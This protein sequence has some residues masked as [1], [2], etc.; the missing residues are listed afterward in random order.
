MAFPQGS[1]YGGTQIYIKGSGF[2]IVN[3]QNQIFINEI[4]CPIMNHYTTEFV[5]SC[6]IPFGFF[7]TADQLIANKQDFYRITVYTAGV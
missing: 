5:L 6:V 2:D 1:I 4:E 7:K 3:F